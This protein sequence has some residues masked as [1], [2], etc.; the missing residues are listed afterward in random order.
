MK[1]ENLNAKIV[2]DVPGCKELAV[3]KMTFSAGAQVQICGKCMSE[4]K[5]AL[6]ER[7]K[8]E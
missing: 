8:G 7:Q 2:C 3:A 6:K 4:I 1:I 5:K